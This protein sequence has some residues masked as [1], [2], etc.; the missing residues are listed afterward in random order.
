MPLQNAVIWALVTSRQV[1]RGAQKCRATAHHIVAIHVWHQNCRFESHLLAC[2]ESIVIQPL[3]VRNRSV[4]VRLVYV[5]NDV[6]D[7]LR[8][9]IELFCLATLQPPPRRIRVWR[10]AVSSLHGHDLDPMSWDLQEPCN[11]LDELDA[12][13]LL[14]PDGNDHVQLHNHA[15]KQRQPVGSF[16]VSAILSTDDQ[17]EESRV[18]VQRMRSMWIV[19]C[20]QSTLGRPDIQTVRNFPTILVDTDG[21]WLA[22]EDSEDNSIIGPVVEPCQ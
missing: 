21:E 14:H 16:P 8:C 20:W 5:L 7:H 13:E 3:R 15:C 22:H 11:I 18:R 2:L 9:L 4:L 10:G 17:I 6:R 1:P 12:V 19:D